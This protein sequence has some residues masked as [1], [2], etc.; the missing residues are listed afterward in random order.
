MPL[1]IDYPPNPVLGQEYYDPSG[2]LWTFEGKS[3][4]G[5]GLATTVEYMPV[6]VYDPFDIAE[7]VYDVDNHT[8]GLVNAVFSIT[9]RD[10]LANQSGT[11][12]GDQTITLTG[13]ITGSGQASF[14]TTLANT[15]VVAGSY[16]LA[17]LQTDSKGRI[18]T[19][20]N[21]DAYAWDTD[22]HTTGSVNSVF[23]LTDKAK[24][25]AQSG[26]NTGDQTIELTGDV[27]GSG[28][29]AFAA[30]LANT[31]VV[32]AAY[33]AANITVD[34]KGRITAAASTNELTNGLLALLN[35][36]LQDG[37]TALDFGIKDYT[38]SI[39]D[40]GTVSTGTV[41]LS[42]EDGG[43][44]KIAVNGDITIEVDTYTSGVAKS[45]QLILQGAASHVI[46]WGST[47]IFSGNLPPSLTIN[48]DRII[49]CTEDG[50]AHVDAMVGAGDYVN[51]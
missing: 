42:F 8:T 20:A 19:I 10:L 35:S 50:G 25:D 44:H 15:G 17:N 43:T 18:I 12:T 26:S 31:A 21:G 16:T 4:V 5:G 40:H 49:L 22:N 13:D 38:E 28:T 30:T 9:E 29:G 32:A 11:N 7:N 46:T 14:A 33:I 34:S 23:S 45:I 1:T 6:S 27:T 3:W 47:I 37:D 51:P 48:R 39:M 36:A 24:L 2:E 41:T